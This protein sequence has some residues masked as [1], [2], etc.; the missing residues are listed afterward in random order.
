MKNSDGKKKTNQETSGK[1]KRKPSSKRGA[2]E[3]AK[4]ECGKF[5]G[6]SKKAIQLQKNRCNAEIRP[7]ARTQPNKQTNR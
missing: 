5:E 2:A 4:E 1:N 7:P 6:T 3:S